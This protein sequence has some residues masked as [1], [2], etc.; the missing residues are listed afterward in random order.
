MY[1]GPKDDIEVFWEDKP[2]RFAHRNNCVG[3]FHRSSNVLRPMMDIAPN[4]MEWF[5]SKEGGKKGYW[6][7]DVSYRDIMKMSKQLSL[8]D[9]MGQE[10]CDSGYCG[11]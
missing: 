5:A 10:G 2:V 8:D 9:L 4:K 1:Y 6:K 3:C 11:F 7:S